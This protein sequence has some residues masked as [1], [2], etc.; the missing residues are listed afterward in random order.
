VLTGRCTKCVLA[1]DPGW[2]DPGNLATAY[3]RRL[4]RA[5]Q[6]SADIPE[7]QVAQ[8]S[9]QLARV[10]SMVFGRCL[11]CGVLPTRPRA[12]RHDAKPAL[13]T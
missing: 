9:C 7:S 4:E 2:P 3:G 1:G 11:S 12:D 5:R 8:P 10:K 6:T 13:A